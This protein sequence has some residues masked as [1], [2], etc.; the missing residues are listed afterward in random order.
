MLC[1][2]LNFSPSDLESVPGR[3]ED[4]FGREFRIIVRNGQLIVDQLVSEGFG[5]D[6]GWSARAMAL[7]AP[8]F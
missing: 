7:V 1:E 8:R 3:G 4:S 6:L 5:P 2:N